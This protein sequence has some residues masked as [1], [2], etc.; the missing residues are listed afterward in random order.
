MRICIAGAPGSALTSAMPS[1]KRSLLSQPRRS[2]TSAW[3]SPQIA[4]G[5][6]PSAPILRNAPTTSS[7]LPIFGF[8]CS[9]SIDLHALL[10]HGR[11]RLGRSQELDE[12]RRSRRILRAE[13]GGR[14]EAGVV[15]QRAGEGDELRAWLADDLA[16]LGQAKRAPSFCERD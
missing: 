9:S 8:T 10:P 14:H 4:A 3:I 13:R 12:C 7:R 5:P 2:C 16:D 6:K 15:L 11:G 1:R